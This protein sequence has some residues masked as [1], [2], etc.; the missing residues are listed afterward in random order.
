[1]IS[2]IKYNFASEASSVKPEY[3]SPFEAKKNTESLNKDKLSI[4]K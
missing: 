3:V 4:R 2:V 1:M